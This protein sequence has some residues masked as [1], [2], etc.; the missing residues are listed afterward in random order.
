MVA[1]IYQAA[2]FRARTSKHKSIRIFGARRKTKIPYVE[3][4]IHKTLKDGLIVRSKSEVIIA[5]MLHQRGIEFEY[6]RTLEENG[7]RCIPDFTFEDASGDPIILEHLGMLNVPSYAEAWKR[8]L[9]FYKSIGYEEGENI[10]TTRDDDNGS[11]DSIAIK[12]VIDEIEDL[13]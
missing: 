7:K 12:K 11:I 13:I 2:V 1:G 6:E 8:K 4:L 5:N 9:E 3:G 10:F